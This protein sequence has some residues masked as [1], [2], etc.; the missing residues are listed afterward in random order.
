MKEI[1]AILQLAAEVMETSLD[2]MTKPV[3]ARH[4]NKLLSRYTRGIFRDEDWR[5]IN[6]LFKAMTAAQIDWTLS[7]TEYRK[8][9]EG[10]PTSKTWSFEIRFINKRGRENTLYGT[11]VAAGA[12]SVAD[13]LDAYDIVAYVN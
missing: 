8:N 6:V 5:H 2:G 11:I 10:V 7:K 13:P 9:D 3:A 1:H 12:G 4:V